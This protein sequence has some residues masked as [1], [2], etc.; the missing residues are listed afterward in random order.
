MENIKRVCKMR[1]ELIDKVETALKKGGVS[2][3]EMGEV[4]DMIKDLYECEEKAY[5]GKYYKGKLEGEE[6]EEKH[7]GLL[8]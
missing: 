5:E 3:K 7:T 4:V 6:G 1:E 2:T 8:R